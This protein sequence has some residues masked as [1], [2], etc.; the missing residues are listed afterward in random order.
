MNGKSGREN[1]S[2][3]RR[4]EQLAVDQTRL[5]RTAKQSLTSDLRGII[6]LER[7]SR[8]SRSLYPEP[9]RRAGSPP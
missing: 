6:T 9:V 2:D 4:E 3:G 7:P 1:E 8:P 5:P